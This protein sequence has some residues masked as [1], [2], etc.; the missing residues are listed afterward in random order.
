MMISN[1]GFYSSYLL[2]YDVDTIVGKD[3]VII[4]Y[5]TQNITCRCQEWGEGDPGT[6][7]VVIFVECKD[8]GLSGE[9][10]VRVKAREQI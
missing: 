1:G 7:T 4:L 5:L 8:P 2:A 3:A 6:D 10:Q 9:R